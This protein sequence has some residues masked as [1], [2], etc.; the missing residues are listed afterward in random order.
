MCLLSREIVKPNRKFDSITGQK[1]WYKIPQSPNTS[2]KKQQVLPDK[3]Q[4]MFANKQIVC[5]EYSELSDLEER[6]IFKVNSTMMSV[7][8]FVLTQ[9]YRGY[10][11]AWL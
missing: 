1:Y 7:C 5:V 9:S 8:V 2:E 10:S 4:T 6:D 11:K 3:L